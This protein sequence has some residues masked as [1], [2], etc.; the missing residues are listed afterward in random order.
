MPALG[1]TLGKAQPVIPQIRALIAA[2]GLEPRPPDSWAA[3]LTPCHGARNLQVML[4]ASN[5]TLEEENKTPLVEVLEKSS[6]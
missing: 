5:P 3:V 4:S 2:L 6:R 1:D